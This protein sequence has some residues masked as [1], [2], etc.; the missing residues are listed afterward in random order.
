MA[1]YKIGINNKELAKFV[2]STVAKTVRKVKSEAMPIVKELREISVIEWFRVA[3]F[4]S[5]YHT[6][7]DS[8]NYEIT[9]KQRNGLVMIDF[10]SYVDSDLYEIQHTSLYKQREKY[11]NID[12]TSYI[13]ESLQWNR[14]I[15]GLPKHS[16][17]GYS[18]W[19]NSYF[20]QTIPL[21][22]YTYEIY[23]SNWVNQ[24]KTKGILK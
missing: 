6:M 20:H 10:T 24:L 4:P 7:L 9:E 22:D 21:Q 1:S 3:G 18:T 14:G 13:V 17:F 15:I 16:D 5:S 19:E 8:L 12:A 11:G 23:R 2:D